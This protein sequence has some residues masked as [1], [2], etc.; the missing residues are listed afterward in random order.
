[1]RIALALSQKDLAGW[2]GGSHRTV[3]R[4]MER[5]RERGV[6][7]TRWRSV[8]IQDTAALCQMVWA[9][10]STPAIDYADPII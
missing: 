1:V 2:V 9:A 10:R 3:A 7:S 8:T 6:I 5:L 4:E